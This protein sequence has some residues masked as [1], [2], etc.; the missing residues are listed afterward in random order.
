M[1]EYQRAKNQAEDLGLHNFVFRGNTYERSTFAN[2]VPCWRRAESDEAVFQGTRKRKMGKMSK[3]S[4]KTK[5]TK[6]AKKSKKS[7]GR[8]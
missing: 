5:K 1:E 7:K 4:K 2:G 6:K 8:K 3:K